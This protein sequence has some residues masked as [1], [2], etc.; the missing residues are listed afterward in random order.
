MPYGAIHIDWQ[1][2]VRLFLQLIRVHVRYQFE[3]FSFGR[4]TRQRERER[5]R[6]PNRLPKKT[7]S[8][9]VNRA[10]NLTCIF[11]G[12][13]RSGWSDS[14]GYKFGRVCGRFGARDIGCARLAVQRMEFAELIAT[15]KLDGVILHTTSSTSNGPV[16]GTLC[17]TGHHL[18]LSSRREGVQELWV[19]VCAS[20]ITIIASNWI[21][22]KCPF[23]S[24]FFFLVSVLFIYICSYCITAS[25]WSNESRRCWTMHCKVVSLRWSAR[26]CA[27]S[28]WK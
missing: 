11:G 2:N 23:F 10:S 6:I 19:S 13:K 20:T 9:Q 15:P 5:E 27:S 18:I 8:I 14:D 25:I 28:R 1:K 12:E 7:P 4:E 17:I 24:S 16:D 3:P 21:C 22:S 26:I